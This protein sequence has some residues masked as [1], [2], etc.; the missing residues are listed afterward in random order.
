LKNQR[1]KEGDKWDMRFAGKRANA[2]PGPRRELTQSGV[3]RVGM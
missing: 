2:I 1:N 3:W